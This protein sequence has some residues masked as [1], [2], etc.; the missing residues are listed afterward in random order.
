[1]GRVSAGVFGSNA[2]DANGAY[3]GRGDRRPLPACVSTFPA[4]QPSEWQYSDRA[5]RRL[6]GGS[7][8]AGARGFE[9]GGFVRGSGKSSQAQGGRTDQD[10]SLTARVFLDFVGLCVWW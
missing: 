6:R 9:G 5:A 2:E 7:A 4:V 1:M 3:G 8:H 10:L